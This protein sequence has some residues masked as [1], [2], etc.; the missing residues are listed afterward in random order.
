[1]P[2]LIRASTAPYNPNSNTHTMKTAHL[3]SIRLS[4]FALG[5][6]CILVGHTS[7]AATLFEDNF[8][9]GIGSHWKKSSSASNITFSADSTRGPVA[10]NQ[11]AFFDATGTN[12]DQRNGVYANFQSTTL[13][14]GDSLTLAFDYKGVK[15]TSNDNNRFIFGLA[16][17]TSGSLAST[18][19]GEGNTV[20]NPGYIT[21][22]KVDLRDNKQS[23]Y[24]DFYKLA[25]LPSNHQTS[26]IG[27]TLTGDSFFLTDAESASANTNTNIA[28]VFHFTLTISR[29]IDGL[30]LTS[31]L[32]DNTAQKSFTITTLVADA[33]VTTY[34]FDTL[35]IGVQ[36][37]ETAE[38]T[39]DNVSV[40][41]TSNIPEPSTI[42]L[43]VG[44]A[45]LVFV[46]LQQRRRHDI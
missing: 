10:G 24:A 1:M 45:A 34:T 22:I 5:L 8:T 11:A 31:I 46:T 25:S 20:T 35:L 2:S 18:T 30:R 7:T 39:I 27:R 36:R 44:L 21:G 32:T 33:N 37:R 23:N 6:T 12:A 13:A 40:T 9:F 3:S 41:L 17:S 26:G 15:Y 29:E 4:L 14:V 38:F 16:Q 19:D 28:D 43:I 42:A